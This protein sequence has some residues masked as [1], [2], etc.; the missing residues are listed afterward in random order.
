MAISAVVAMAFTRYAWRATGQSCAPA[1]NLF[2]GCGHVSFRVLLSL[3]GILMVAVAAVEQWVLAQ[4]PSAR[5]YLGLNGADESAMHI[6]GS[7]KT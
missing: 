2:T 6:D 7:S 3:L 1:L 4:I 5:K